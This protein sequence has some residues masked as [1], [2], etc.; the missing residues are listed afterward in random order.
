MAQVTTD[1]LTQ[2]HEAFAGN[3]LLSTFSPEARA[4]IEPFGTLVELHPGEIV[5]TRGE[6]VSA[7]LFPVG[8]TMITMVVELS[9]GRTVEVASVGREALK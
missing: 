3:R 1:E 9:G 7:S 6:Q 4:L 5:L 2:A 8:P